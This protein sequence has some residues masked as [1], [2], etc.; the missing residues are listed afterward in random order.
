MDNIVPS[1]L[2]QH[3]HVMYFASILVLESFICS[4][5]AFAEKNQGAK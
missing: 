3:V 5:I 4:N 2:S 1:H